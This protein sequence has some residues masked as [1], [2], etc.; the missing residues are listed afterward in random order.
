MR[1]NFCLMCVECLLCKGSNEKKVSFIA[2]K[3]QD[4]ELVFGQVQQPTLYAQ[5]VENWLDT[6]HKWL[7]VRCPCLRLFVSVKVTY[8]WRNIFGNISNI[9]II[10]HGWQRINITCYTIRFPRRN[11]SLPGSGF[12]TFIRCPAYVIFQEESE[13]MLFTAVLRT[14]QITFIEFLDLLSLGSLKYWAKVITISRFR[15]STKL[16]CL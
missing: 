11:I 15:Q 8:L 2:W 12:I 4:T 14:N 9:S 10:A 7:L 5:S 16:L 1:E 3:L 13:G 6:I